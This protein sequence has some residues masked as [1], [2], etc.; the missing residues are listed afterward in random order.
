[1]LVVPLIFSALVLGVAGLGDLRRLG[2]VGLKTLAYTVCVS[3]IAVLL[4]VL[5]VNLLRPGDGVSPEARAR[6]LAGAA[7]GAGG[8]PPERARTGT[9]LLVQIVPDNPIKA[10]ADGDMLAVMFFA[11]CFGIG[12]R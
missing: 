6:L 1:M 12:L 8:D 5:L 4:G 9:E 3:A 10:A 11:L 2:R 7:S